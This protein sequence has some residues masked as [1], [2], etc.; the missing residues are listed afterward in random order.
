MNTDEQRKLELAARVMGLKFIRRD[1]A[2]GLHLLSGVWFRPHTDD[3]DSRRLEL[4]CMKWLAENEV[5]HNLAALNDEIA[6][7]MAKGDAAGTRAAVLAL[8][9][10]IGE[11]MDAPADIGKGG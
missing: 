3:G 6:D 1:F 7:P 11:V 9:D 5:P 8:A 10:A 4:A 2:Q